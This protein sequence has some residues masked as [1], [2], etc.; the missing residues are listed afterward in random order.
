[1]F[2][3]LRRSVVESPLGLSSTLAAVH[4]RNSTLRRCR[5]QHG[6][7]GRRLDGRDRQGR[8]AVRHVLD[9]VGRLQQDA[10]FRVERVEGR[11]DRDDCVVLLAATE[12][13]S[14][15][16]SDHRRDGVGQ[17]GQRADVSAV[18]D[19][20]RSC[21]DS[22]GGG[23]QLR[24]CGHVDDVAV[25]LLL[26]DLVALLRVPGHVV[27]RLDR[28]IVVTERC[29]GD[30][31]DAI[32]GQGGQ[33]RVDRDLVERGFSGGGDA[34]QD[35]VGLLDACGDH[36]RVSVGEVV[37][38]LERAVEIGGGA[39]DL[40]S[41]GFGNGR[42]GLLDVV[43]VQGHDDHLLISCSDLMIGVGD[44][45]IRIDATKLIACVCNQVGDVYCVGVPDV[46]LRE[47]Y[48]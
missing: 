3:V 20:R 33:G 8:G 40:L 38:A 14:A 37:D 43:H 25:V 7:G 34:S 42:C 2:E 22:V 32:A 4:I 21:A 12:L 6:Q 16:L 45:I 27:D 47:Y 9:V 31:A 46:R 10:E 29:L 19:G 23:S 48:L 26:L 35:V 11:L 39:D 18:F 28:H 30:R 24:D 1:M 5:T 44:G 41:L 17:L 15:N 36:L 13:A